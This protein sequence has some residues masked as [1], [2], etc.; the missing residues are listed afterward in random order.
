MVAT[1][2][3]VPRAG[4]VL[5]RALKATKTTA[6]GRLFVPESA[7]ERKT[8][9]GLAEVLVV[10]QH[11]TEAGVPVE[12]PLKQGDLALF[13]DWLKSAN[14]VSELLGESVGTVFLLHIRD[15]L[16]VIDTSGGGSM[17]VGHNDEYQL[18]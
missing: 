3:I 4:W 5:C 2:T 8:T 13:R 6:T 11:C 16:A 14:D 12:A 17:T 18:D 1:T 10:R 7:G 15:V 9:E